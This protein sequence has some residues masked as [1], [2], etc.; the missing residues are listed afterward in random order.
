MKAKLP[1]LKLQKFNGKQLEDWQ[2]FW[3]Q[4]RSSI[5][6]NSH[7]DTVNK[8]IYLRNLLEKVALATVEG[9]KISAANYVRVK[10]TSQK[11]FG[12]I[13]AHIDSLDRM[14]GIKNPTSS[15]TST[16]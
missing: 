15:M 12:D 10:D 13:Q 1:N 16:A 8:W 7:V 3:K 9:I 2:P 4:F 5:D 6:Q 11:K 14:K